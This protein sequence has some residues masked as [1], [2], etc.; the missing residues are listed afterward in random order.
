MR[1]AHFRQNGIKLNA[2][3][4]LDEMAMYAFRCRRVHAV[5]DYVQQL[6]GIQPGVCFLQ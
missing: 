2:H 1:I 5:L 6:S 4:V 3:A